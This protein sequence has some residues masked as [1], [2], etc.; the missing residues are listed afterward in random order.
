MT[1]PQ[2]REEQAQPEISLTRIAARATARAVEG[3]AS[4]PKPVGEAVFELDDVTVSY[5]GKTAVRDISF[6]IPVREITALI[7]PSGCGKSTLIRCLNRMNDL[8]PGAE[9]EGRIL[10]HGQDLYDA[11]VD[12]V[13]VRK[14]IGMVFQ[15][16]NPFPK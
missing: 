14:R 10:Y 6:D 1:E 4:E 5:S 11:H 8:I 7:G 9:V 3:A 16:R 2:D 13:E 12:A 15:K